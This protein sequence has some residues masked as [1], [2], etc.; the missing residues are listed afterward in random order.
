MEKLFCWNDSGEGI[1]HC[2]I[3]VPFFKYVPLIFFTQMTAQMAFM[4]A[5]FAILK[6]LSRLPQGI[7]RFHYRHLGSIR[8]RLSVIAFLLILALAWWFGQV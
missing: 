5:Y 2:I 7:A 6:N 4:K 3:Y 8:H 1:I